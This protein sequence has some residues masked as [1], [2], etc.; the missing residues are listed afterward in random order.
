[1]KPNLTINIY[2]GLRAVKAGTANGLPQ[3]KSSILGPYMTA[4]ETYRRIFD[5]TEAGGLALASSQSGKLADLLLSYANSGGAREGDVDGK[6]KR[7]SGVA[8]ESKAAQKPSNMSDGQGSKVC[9]GGATHKPLATVVDEPVQSMPDIDMEA[10]GG[11]FSMKEEDAEE[12]L[13][14]RDKRGPLMRKVVSFVHTVTTAFLS[15]W[16]V[17]ARAMEGTCCV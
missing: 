7:P 2:L 6:V 16:R 10:G 4:M 14:V 1:M 15:P 8:G 5:S 13:M 17:L 9:P 12:G 11:E 3:S